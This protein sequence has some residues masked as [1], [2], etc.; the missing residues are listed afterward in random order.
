MPDD[1]DLSE[2]EIAFAT[3]QALHKVKLT[4]RLP[5]RGNCYNCGDPLGTTDLFCAGGECRDDWQQREAGL[6]RGG[7]KPVFDAPEETKT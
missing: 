7:E 3:Q 5:P 1:A 4:P 2:N 6:A